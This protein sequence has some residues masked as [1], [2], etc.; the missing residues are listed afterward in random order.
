VTEAEVEAAF[1]RY[2]EDDGWSVTLNGKDHLDVRATKAGKTLLAE[3][4]GHTKSP[5]TAV[6]IGFGQLLRRMDFDRLD[7]R[8]CLVVPASL[9]TFITR[10]APSVFARAGIE[11]FVVSPQGDVSPFQR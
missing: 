9:E 10:I 2:L 1:V 8:Y 11:V 6:D 7:E 4:K 3:V 5:G